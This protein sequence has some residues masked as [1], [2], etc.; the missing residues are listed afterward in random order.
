M[1]TPTRRRFIICAS[2]AGAGALA[3]TAGVAE[4]V[5]APSFDTFPTQPPDLV[6]EMVG[7]S[8]ANAARVRELLA[9]HPSLANAA[10][11]WGFGDWETAL[12]A[13][14]HMGQVEIARALLAHGA[15]PTIFSA[16]MLGQLAVVRAFVETSPQVR[17][18][19]GPHGITLLAHARAGGES[20]KPVLDYLTAIG[21]ADPVPRSV[22]LPAGAAS[23]YGGRYAFGSRDQDVIEIKLEK[24]ALSFLRQGTVPRNLVHL[25]DDTFHPSGVPTVKIRFAI[26]GETATEL[27]VF[28]PDLVLRAGRVSLLDLGGAK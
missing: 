7:V 6:R 3:R 28:D 25:G 14:S 22:E 11:D 8:H 24:S 20:A 21:G 19:P 23:R 17:G 4:P 26:A 16:A 5:V 2:L 27:T 13:A 10:W 12:G 1:E 15:R 9:R 18:T